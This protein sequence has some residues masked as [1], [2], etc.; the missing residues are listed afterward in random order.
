[1]QDD[2]KPH[3]FSATVVELSESL[4]ISLID[5]L[6]QAC[7]EY[8]VPFDSVTN[9]SSEST[10][11]RTNLDGET[12]SVTIVDN[13][14]LITPMLQTRLEKESIENGLIEGELQTQLF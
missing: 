6:V 1:M 3:Q 5:A 11:T 2:V 10:Q 13:V 12:T 7:I 8:D 9:F 14:N 4:S